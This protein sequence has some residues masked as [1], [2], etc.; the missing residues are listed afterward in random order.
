MSP[1][2]KLIPS[3]ESLPRSADVVII[4]AGILGAS[5]AFY[6]ARRGVSVALVE[7]G[8]VGCEQSSRN[9]GWCRQQ[10]RDPREMPLSMLAMG[11]WDEAAADIGE[12]LGFRRCGL[13][14]ASDDEKQLA[15]WEKWQDVAR[16]FGVETR[17]LSAAE[18]AQKIPAMK[19]KWR[20]G[21]HAARDGKAEP[22]LAAPAFA[23]GARKL[24]ATI[25]QQCAAHGVDFVNGTVRGVQTEKGYI[26]ANAV[27]CS[28]GVWASAFCHSLGISFPQASIRQT[29]LRSRPAPNIG[30]IIYTPDCALTRRLDGSYTMAISGRA[31]LEVTPQGLRYAKPFIPMF[32]KRLKAVRLSVGESF[33]S[34][35]ESLAT[36]YS[37]KPH[38]FGRIRTL[39]PD[40]SQSMMRAVLAR[41]RSN[42]PDLANIEVAEA[43]G[44]Y[45]D[46]T[47]D[48]LPVISPLESAPGLFLAAGCSGHGFGLGPGVGYLAAQLIAN[49]TPTADPAPF[50][51]SRLL[52]GSKIEVGP[53]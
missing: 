26:A 1:T 35:P 15:E 45:V 27:L 17:M 28:A 25:H 23:S 34:G 12:D 39:D 6:L 18:V 32:K 11:L 50:R 20:G 38:R 2:V 29:A 8:N 30:E 52:D 42:F 53:I 3:D 41:V 4:G 37:G 9:W 31:T 14:Y 47:P 46:S 48:A 5:A 13:V 24:G 19:R 36:W 10:N 43:W 33:I 44:A 22:A 21:L 49:E 16:R 7:K 51:L 40:P